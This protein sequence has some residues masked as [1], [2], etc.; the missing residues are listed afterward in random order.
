MTCYAPPVVAAGHLTWEQVLLHV[1]K[2]AMQFEEVRAEQLTHH[3]VFLYAIFLR[4]RIDELAE[5]DDPDLNASKML[6][7]LNK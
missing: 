1:D 5:M 7:V 3:V 4:K 2:I 6:G